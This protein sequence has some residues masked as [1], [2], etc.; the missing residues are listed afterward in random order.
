VKQ[1]TFTLAMTALALVLGYAVYALVT[2][3]G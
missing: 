3:L 1:W 2:S